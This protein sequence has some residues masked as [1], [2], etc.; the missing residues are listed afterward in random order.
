MPQPASP[1]RSPPE[2][3]RGLLLH[4]FVDRPQWFELGSCAVDTG[5]HAGAF[6]CLVDAQAALPQPSGAVL[7]PYRGRT[8]AN[9]EGL[10]LALLP[11][12]GEEGGE[13]FNRTL[14]LI[15]AIRKEVKDDAYFW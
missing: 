4:I 6:I 3:D 9:A 15:D 10:V 7:P 12:I 5:T 14:A 8:P 13:Y 11:G 2:N 1:L